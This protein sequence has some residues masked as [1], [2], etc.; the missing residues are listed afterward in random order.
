MEIGAGEQFERRRGTAEIPGP[1]EFRIDY[2]LVVMVNIF[3]IR[4]R[5]EGD[6]PVIGGHDAVA[7][8]LVPTPMMSRL[9]GPLLDSD[10]GA[11][12]R[13]PPRLHE[14]RAT[15]SWLQSLPKPS[16]NHAVSFFAAPIF[17]GEA[18]RPCQSRLRAERVIRGDGRA[19]FTQRLV[20]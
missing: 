18:Q 1:G 12:L 11:S 3:S 10:S 9:F 19:R 8:R 2:S 13:S 6:E 16:G 14:R 15:P 20:P 4:F 5:A 17:A 7:Q